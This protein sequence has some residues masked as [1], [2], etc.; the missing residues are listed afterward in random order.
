MFKLKCYLFNK[1]YIGN[2]KGN[3]THDEKEAPYPKGTKNN[4]ITF[5][6]L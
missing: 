2:N 4:Y 5:I 6:S 1:H 3:K